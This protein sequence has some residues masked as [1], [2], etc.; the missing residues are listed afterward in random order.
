MADFK[1]PG[2]ASVETESKYIINCLNISEITREETA[3]FRTAVSEERK[4]KAGRFVR[5]TDTIRCICG[6]LLLRYSFYQKYERFPEAE[7]CYNYN[8]FGKPVLKD[9][10]QMHFNISHSGDWVGIVYGMDEVGLDIERIPSDS[11]SIF[12]QA[13]HRDEKHWLKKFDGEE[14][15]KQAVRLWTVKESYLKYIG[16]GLATDMD[17]FAI[18]MEQGTVM[19]YQGI[20]GNPYWKSFLLDEEHYLTICGDNRDIEMKLVSTEELKDFLFKNQK[21]IQSHRKSDSEI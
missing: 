19:W 12:W 13:F 2:T 18:L 3:L 20:Q 21:A 14:R 4:R 15:V 7:L 6:E 5:E 8:Q 1:E 10:E 11:E 17:S 16:T 9:M